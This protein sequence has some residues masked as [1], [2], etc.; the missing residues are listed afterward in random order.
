MNLPTMLVSIGT[1]GMQ[2]TEMN[3]C[4]SY[5]HSMQL[6][7]RGLLT[8]VAWNGCHEHMIVTGPLLDRYIMSKLLKQFCSI[9]LILHFQC[10]SGG[11]KLECLKGPVSYQELMSTISSICP[12]VC[13][14]QVEVHSTGQLPDFQ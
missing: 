2:N 8:S 3:N 9:Y 1:L 4:F 13:S 5:F 6:T 14:H 10:P 7:N 11:V 12:E